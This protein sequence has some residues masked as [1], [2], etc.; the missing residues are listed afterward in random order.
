MSNNSSLSSRFV[1]VDL[2][3]INYRVPE[4]GDPRRDNWIAAIEEYQ[5][6]Q[7]YS[8]ILVCSA[9]FEDSMFV[10]NRNKLTLTQTAVPTLL[11]TQ[12]CGAESEVDVGAE[13]EFDIGAESEVDVGAINEVAEPQNENLIDILKNPNE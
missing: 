3:S 2:F 12:N 11:N 6:F 7:H 10:M 8:R 13:S 9:H 4:P 1:Y 5:E